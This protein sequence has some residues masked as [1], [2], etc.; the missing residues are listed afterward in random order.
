M[1]T[2]VIVLLVLIIGYFI[3]KK[4]VVD[5]P[6]EDEKV[7]ESYKSFTGENKKPLDLKSG[8]LMRMKPFLGDPNGPF[9][10][11]VYRRT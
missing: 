11:P 2:L 4:K 6:V 9:F 7:T 10:E 1:V 3:F 5:R 8:F